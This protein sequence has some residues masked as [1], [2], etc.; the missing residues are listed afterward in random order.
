M[1]HGPLAVSVH[2]SSVT[3]SPAGVPASDPPSPMWTGLGDT[4]AAYGMERPSMWAR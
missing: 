3:F 2:D 4:L 1:R